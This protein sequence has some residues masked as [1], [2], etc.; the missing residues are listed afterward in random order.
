MLGQANSTEEMQLLFLFM[1]S[2]ESPDNTMLFLSPFMSFSSFFN[3]F[4][5]FLIRKKKLK[6]GTELKTFSWILEWLWQAPIRDACPSF[7][8]RNSDGETGKQR[9]ARKNNSQKT[10]P[11]LRTKYSRGIY[12]VAIAA[13]SDLHS[14]INHDAL[15]QG[16]NTQSQRLRRR[17]HQFWHMLTTPIFQGWENKYLKVSLKPWILLFWYNVAFIVLLNEI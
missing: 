16:G 8:G 9:W 11:P 6:K 12:S 2:K 3:I 17:L 5:S 7:R 10:A 13:Y 14:G 4:L 15:L 1:E